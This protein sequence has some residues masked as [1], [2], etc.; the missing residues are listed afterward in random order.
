MFSVCLSVRSQTFVHAGIPLSGSDLSDYAYGG[1]API[2]RGTW[3]G[4]GEGPAMES[5]AA[6]SIRWEIG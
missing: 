4:F 6:L 5:A 3:K 2:L 1:A